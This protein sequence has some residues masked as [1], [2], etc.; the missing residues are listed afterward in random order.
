MC[1]WLPATIMTDNVAVDGGTDIDALDAQFSS[2]V[3]PQLNPFPNWQELTT[4]PPP[5]TSCLGGHLY[6]RH[7]TGR[8]WIYTG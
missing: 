4:T 1:Y 6:Q 8:I 7:N 2:G 3:Y 5:S